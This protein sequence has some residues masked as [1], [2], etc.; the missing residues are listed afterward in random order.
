MRCVGCDKC[1]L[2]G[3]LQVQGLATALKIL[4]AT[5]DQNSDLGSVLN[6]QRNEVVALF[7]VLERLSSS[8]E[9]DA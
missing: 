3:K 7:N 1:R 5:D 6:L 2:W 8:L 4:F 9:V